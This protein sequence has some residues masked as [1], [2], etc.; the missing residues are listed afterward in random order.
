MAREKFVLQAY[1][2][3]LAPAT[4]TKECTLERPAAGT[5][6][7]VGV[8]AAGRVGDIRHKLPFSGS[9]TERKVIPLAMTVSEFKHLQNGPYGWTFHAQGE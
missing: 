3:S 5:W 2:S 4:L 6:L 9:E 8:Y 1:S 7:Q